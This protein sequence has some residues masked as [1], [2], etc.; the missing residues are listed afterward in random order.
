M[1]RIL[2]LYPRACQVLCIA[3]IIHCHIFAHALHSWNYCFILL[4]FSCYFEKN[5]CRSFMRITEKARRV[6][7]F[8][9]W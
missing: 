9:S 5:F 7:A 6:A 1:P 4:F 2:V 3:L 8:L